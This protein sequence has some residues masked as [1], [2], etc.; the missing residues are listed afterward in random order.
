MP[1]AEIP[2]DPYH[3][4]TSERQIQVPGHKQI[5]K[6]IQRQQQTLNTQGRSV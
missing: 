3:P 1:T 6:L 4:K 2:T 5:L